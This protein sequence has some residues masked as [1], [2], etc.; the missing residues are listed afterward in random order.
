MNLEVTKGLPLFKWTEENHQGI[1]TF[2]DPVILVEVEIN[3]VSIKEEEI[4]LLSRW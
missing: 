4:N 1:Q 3:L 2:N